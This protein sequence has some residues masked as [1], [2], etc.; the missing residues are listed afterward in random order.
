MLADFQALKNN[1]IKPT[2]NRGAKSNNS[3]R[4]QTVF[5]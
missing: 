1:G 3:Q 2:K 5:K 4:F